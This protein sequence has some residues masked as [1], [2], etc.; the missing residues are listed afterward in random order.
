MKFVGEEFC[1]G[2][3]LNAFACGATT[4][5]PIDKRRPRIDL[6][7]LKGAETTFLGILIV[8]G[9]GDGGG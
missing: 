2:G 9:D 4:S 6:A 1:A 5:S 3:I 7:C 8:D